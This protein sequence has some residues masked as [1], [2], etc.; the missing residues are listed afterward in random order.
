M[1]HAEIIRLDKHTV[2]QDFRPNMLKEKGPR[3]D[4]DY[5]VRFSPL[6][7]CQGYERSETTEGETRRMVWGRHVTFF[8][9]SGRVI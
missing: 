6:A 7:A 5:L 2:N 8:V 9:S 3:G 4:D 1:P